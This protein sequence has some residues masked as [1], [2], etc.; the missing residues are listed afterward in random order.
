MGN[1]RLS[2]LLVSFLVGISVLMAPLLRLVPMSVLFGVFLY[3][4]VSSTNGIQFFERLQ[5]FFMPVKHH[6]QTAYVRRVH[7]MKMHLF[8]FV[9]IMCLAILWVVKSTR[10]SLAFPFFLV[11]MI[12]L[13]AQLKHVFTPQEL[14]VIE[15]VPTHRNCADYLL[16]PEQN[17]FNAEQ[18]GEVHGPFFIE[19]YRVPREIHVGYLGVVKTKL[20]A[21]NYFWWPRMNKVIENYA[22]GRHTCRAVRQLP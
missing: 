21:K 10:I 18:G 12:P 14:R 7:M 8:T 6:P 20:S 13:R 22:L 19:A 4:G 5:L 16:V 15:F 3:M 17:R 2:A 1:Q 9:Q 11:L